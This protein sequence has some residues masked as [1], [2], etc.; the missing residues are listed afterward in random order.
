MA[1]VLGEL[2]RE[3]ASFVDGV[4]RELGP[5][6]DGAPMWKRDAVFVW[7][8]ALFTN[9]GGFLRLLD[10]RFSGDPGFSETLDA[11]VRIG[12][13]EAA[14]I[15]RRWLSV[16]PEGRI[17]D[18]HNERYDYYHRKPIEL[19]EG[20]DDAY[21]RAYPEV[22]NRLANYIRHQGLEQTR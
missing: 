1:N 6:L 19:R 14:E 12:A 4:V 11:L 10:L 3:I 17:P 9:N 15:F 22:V 16:F 13:H 8:T 2:E 7:W 21:L 5:D 20:L 18:D